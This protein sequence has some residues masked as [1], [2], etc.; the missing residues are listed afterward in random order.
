MPSGEPERADAGSTWR[1]FRP[2]S[3]NYARLVALAVLTDEAGRIL[4]ASLGVDRSF[5]DDRQQSASARDIAKSFLYWALPEQDQADVVAA[6]EAAG[7]GAQCG[8]GERRR[9][10]DEER[11]LG[12]A[13]AGVA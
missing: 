7:A 4:A 1:E 2:S 3:P 6:L 12:E 9:V 11:Q 13:L 10:V 8:D 5:L